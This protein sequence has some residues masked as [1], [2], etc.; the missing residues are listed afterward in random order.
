MDNHI[1]YMDHFFIHL[2]PLPRRYPTEAPVQS[3]GYVRTKKEY[4]DQSFQTLNFSLLL[5]G[6]GTYEWQG[7]RFPVQAPC[8]ITQ[9]PGITMRYGPHPGTTWDELFLIYRED[10]RSMFESSNLLSLRKPFWPIQRKSTVLDSFVALRELLQN[11]Q[12]EGFVD[13]VDR[14][15]ELL[16]FQTHLGP[17]VRTTTSRTEDAIE[18]IRKH[19]RDH[20]FENHDFEQLAHAQ[21]LSASTFRRYWKKRVQDPPARYVTNLRMRT[22]CRLLAESDLT[23]YEIAVRTGFEDAFY[24]SRCFR[25]NTGMPP[26]TYRQQHRPHPAP[27]ARG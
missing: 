7:Q 14:L 24:F 21:G 27:R 4:V 1:N 8:V 23:I 5:Q 16:L 18:A 19:V 17:H 2:A 6:A 3:I 9:W 26:R 25:Q 22:A 15:C 10:T 11:P 13:R 12:E 20:P